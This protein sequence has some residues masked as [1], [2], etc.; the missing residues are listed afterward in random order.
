MLALGRCEAQLQMVSPI[1][2]P[3]QLEVPTSPGAACCGIG[4]GVCLSLAPYVPGARGHEG[5]DRPPR[6]LM[7]PFIPSTISPYTGSKI[8]RNF[9][10]NLADRLRDQPTAATA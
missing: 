8:F 10:R 4:R 2:R 9:A 1:G 3:P 5:G 6:A 7:L